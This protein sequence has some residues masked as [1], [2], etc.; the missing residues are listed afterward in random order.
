M[1]RFDAH[2]GW[3][4]T[5]LPFEERFA[6]VAKAGFKAIENPNLYDYSTEQLSEWLGKYDLKLI[7]TATPT[8]DPTKGDRGLACR[9]ERVGEFRDGVGKAIEFAQTFDCKILHAMAGLKAPDADLEAYHKTYIDNLRFTGRACAEN[10]IKVIL[11]PISAYSV[12]DF[13]LNSPNMA[14]QAINDSGDDNLFLLF[15]YFHAQC[16]QGNLVQFVRD[17]LDLIG[18]IQVADA[19]GRNEP[20][21]GEINYEY[22]LSD[23]D[24]LGYKG[25]IGCEYKPSTDTTTSL[26]WLDPASG[27]FNF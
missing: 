24:D 7:S 16:S 19:P 5:D 21:S 25:W 12:P 6:A 13:Y 23:L 15:D 8:G 20:G 9:P 27:K 18:H 22:V 3:L 1:L 2:I 17:H 10:G 4:Y 14:V 11:E 26:R